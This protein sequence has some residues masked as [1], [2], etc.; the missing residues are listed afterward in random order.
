MSGGEL[1]HA[2]FDLAEFGLTSIAD[3]PSD[4]FFVSEVEEQSG[5]IIRAVPRASEKF[6]RHVKLSI[7]GRAQAA[8]AS[9]SSQRESAASASSQRESVGLEASGKIVVA[10]SQARPRVGSITAGSKKVS[11]AIKT[12][13]RMSP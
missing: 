5:G 11:P 8:S 1:V 10:E 3:L 12:R 7:S 13:G 2:E 9:V 4:G 6:A